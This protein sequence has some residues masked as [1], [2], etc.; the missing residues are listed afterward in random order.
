MCIFVWGKLDVWG[1]FGVSFG[2]FVDGFCVL[3]FDDLC[4]FLLVF[5]D[6]VIEVLDGFCIVFCVLFVGVFFC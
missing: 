3:F 5:W 2:C 6:V 4:M 1:G